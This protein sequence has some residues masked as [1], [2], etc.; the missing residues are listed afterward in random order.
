MFD[1]LIKNGTVMDGSG[2][3]AV[4]ADVGIKG[5]KIEAIGSL[6]DAQAAKVIDAAGMA[7]APGFI[8]MHSHGD[9]MLP[10]LPTAD[11]KIY[12]G[13]TTEVVGNCGSSMAPM[14]DV[15]R[16][17]QNESYAQAGPAR[18]VS[19]LTFEEYLDFIRNNGISVNMY[20]LVGHGAVRET[21]MGM[22]DAEPTAKQLDEMKSEV[23]KAMRAGARGFSTG[24]IYTPSVYAKTDE[25]I[26]LTQVAK[27]E[28]G[29]YT[30]HIRGEANTLLEALDEAIEIGRQTGISVEISHFKASGI[31]N[32]WKMDKA[33]EKLEKARA[34]GMNLHA[35]MYPY[36]ASN[37]GL[38]SIIPS[39][40]HVGGRDAMIARL[41]NPADRKQIHLELA[42][43]LNT[44]HI[45]WDKI[46]VSSCPK[47]PEVEGKTLQQIADER[48]LHPLDASMDLLIETEIN[49]SIIM[50][51]INE[52]NVEKGLVLP[53]VSIGSDGSGYAASGP[54]AIG[55][56]HPR[57][58][59]TFARVLGY[60]AREKELFSMEEAVRKMTSLPASKLGLTDRGLLKPGYYA[61]IAVFDSLTVRDT[62]TFTDPKHYAAGIPWV[63]TNGKVV[64]ENGKH[65]GGL[66][67]MVL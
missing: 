30:S 63:L 50:F 14:N 19:W 61:D 28:G 1:V 10:F 16:T 46:M 36:H 58:F 51:T 42:D 18:E 20:P 11:S 55:K 65:N 2:T 34:E 48:N 17:E 57:N 24:L 12:M 44:V 56:P 60:Y 31:Y 53:Y 22:S 33:I 26:A 3:P 29:I 27:D 6:G 54:Y 7:V 62:A 43:N 47:L 21:V 66:P 9:G 41:K 4:K 15:M 25:L 39:W 52:E 49:V 13:V 8:D 35:D 59:G 40:A 23:R 32:W 38:S 37:T 5:N 64:I 67:G 45:G